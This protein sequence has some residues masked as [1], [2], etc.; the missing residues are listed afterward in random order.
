MLNTVSIRTKLFILPLLF[1]VAMMG[2]VILVTTSLQQNHADALIVNVAGR[3][4]MLTKKFSAEELYRKNSH[5]ENTPSVLNADKTVDLYQLSL[6]A[7]QQGGQTYLDLA[8]TKTIQLPTPSHQPFI[9][10]L[11]KVELL[12]KEQLEAALKKMHDPSEA[13]TN[14][15]LIIN[16]KAL[17]SMDKAVLIYADYAK[18]KLNRLTKNSIILAVIMA[19]ISFMLAWFVIKETTNPINKLVSITRKISR[20]DLKPSAELH[21]IVSKNEVGLLAHHIELMRESLQDALSQIQQASSSIQQSSS[22]VSVLSEQIGKANGQEQQGFSDMNDNSIILEESTA[23]L[24]EITADTL[25]MITECDQLSTNASN[26]I[27]EN[28]VMM[29]TTVEETNKASE[30]IQTLS[31]TAEKVYGIVDAIRAISGQ[32][33]LLALN[34]AIEAARAGEQGRGFAVVADEVRNLAARTGKSTDEISVLI[35]QLTD[36]VQEVVHSM[37]EVANKVGQSRETSIKTEQGI[38]EVTE[39]IQLVAQAQKNIDEQVDN[40]NTQL[41]TL[42]ITQKELQ[43]IIEESHKKSQ[44]SSLVASQLSKVSHNITN[45]LQQL[46]IE[47]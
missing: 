37:A 45:L 43:V 19:F 5:T 23:R 36:G 16:H 17:A 33:N 12:W 29:A 28:I 26:L 1:T 25:I 20:G 11:T 9:D 35:T 24:G 32:T 27:S 47:A 21:G 22:Q 40:Q 38:T 39:K 46:L 7:L 3:Q 18:Q 34:A 8:M 6:K 31:Y 30:L 10:Q 4:R 41:T 42:K 14:A 15:F 2:E 44:T 13:N